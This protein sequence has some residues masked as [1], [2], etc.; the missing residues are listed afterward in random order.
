MK[1][2]NLLFFHSCSHLVSMATYCQTKLK[3]SLVKHFNQQLL[4]FTQT[5]ASEADHICMQYQLHSN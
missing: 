5:F 1:I 3:G 4:D 2:V